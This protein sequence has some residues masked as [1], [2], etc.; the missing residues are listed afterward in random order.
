MT[1]NFTIEEKNKYKKMW[2]VKNYSNYS[3]GEVMV[4]QALMLCTDFKMK[5]ILDAGCGT[6]R[7]TSLFNALGLDA[8]GV[9]I[10][11]SHISPAVKAKIGDKLHEECLWELSFTEPFDLIYCIDVLE[12]IPPK[13]LYKTISKLASLCK[14]CAYFKIAL[15]QDGYGKQIG[16]TLHLSLYKTDQWIQM[17]APHFGDINVISDDGGNLTLVCEAKCKDC[18]HGR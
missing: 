6:G 12:H 11:L 15:Y 9:D 1:D 7:A 13:R 16:E 17:L 8:T 2:A 5:T 3:P 10:T 18:G 14:V 4:D